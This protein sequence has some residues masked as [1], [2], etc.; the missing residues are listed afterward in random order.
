MN[1]GL[2]LAIPCRADEPG[3]GATLTSLL[4]ACRHAGLGGGVVKELLICLNGLKRDVSCASLVAARTFCT[5][6]GIPSREIWLDDSCEPALSRSGQP[7]TARE[8]PDRSDLGSQQTET[9]AAHL[10]IP[11]CTLL[12]TERRGKPLAW[13]ALVRYAVGTFVLF[14][15]ADVRVDSEAVWI[16][17]DRVQ[18]E[19]HLSL[20]AAREVPV[21][22]GKSTVWA[23]MGALPYR[24]NFGNVGGRL[25]LFRKGALRD[26]MPEDLLLED[27]WL[28][29]AVGKHCVAKEWRA[30]VSFLPP[31]T[32]LDYFAERVRT[33]GGKIQIR[34]V[35]GH[36]LE[37]GPIATYPWAQLFSAIAVREYPLVF[38]ALL[39][40]GVARIWARLALVNKEFYALYRPFLTTKDWSRT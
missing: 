17:C 31:A 6:F 15:D 38:L 25:F 36:L 5:E 26:G 37:A 28:T 22:E 20:V 10:P 24:F 35:H 11:A 16:L 27:A 34:R 12:L 8:D 14:C 4:A 2:S 18:R 33:E 32:G 40:R 29:I 21:L 7:I 3:L 9:T 23:R 30:Q 19:P 1:S 13:N 39:M